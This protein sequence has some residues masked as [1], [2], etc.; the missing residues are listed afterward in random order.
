MVVKIKLTLH[1]SQLENLTNEARSASMRST[2]MR[3]LSPL[4][5]RNVVHNMPRLSTLLSPGYLKKAINQRATTLKFLSV[6]FKP[7]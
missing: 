3:Y 6:V 1:L 7:Y 2:D 4:L 5:C